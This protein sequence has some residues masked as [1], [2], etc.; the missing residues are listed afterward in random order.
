MR[1]CHAGLHRKIAFDHLGKF[2]GHEI[3]A[4][5]ACRHG[6]LELVQRKAGL[7]C[8][9]GRLGQGDEAGA[10]VDVPSRTIT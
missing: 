7:A 1:V 9:I 6:L 5:R 4:E 3:A 8:K 2:D 10:K